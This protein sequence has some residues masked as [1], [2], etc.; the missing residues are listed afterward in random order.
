M[1][2]PK[3]RVLHFLGASGLPSV[4]RELQQ[5]PTRGSHTQTSPDAVVLRPHLSF[6]GQGSPT[7]LCPSPPACLSRK[8]APPNESCRDPQ[9]QAVSPSSLL[10]DLT[11]HRQEQ[12]PCRVLADVPSSHLTQPEERGDSQSTAYPGSAP[13]AGEEGRARGPGASPQT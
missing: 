3:S 9:S 13:L 1:A 10:N 4:K 11:R 2:K 7:I 8:P 5:S 6:A 12:G